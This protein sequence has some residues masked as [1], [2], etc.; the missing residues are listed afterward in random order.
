MMGMSAKA[1]QISHVEGGESERTEFCGYPVHQLELL[2]VDYKDF[3]ERPKLRLPGKG[4]ASRASLQRSATHFM[5]ST[6]FLH[7]GHE[8]SRG[9]G[10]SSAS[11]QLVKE[12]SS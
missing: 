8:Y 10:L 7:S 3:R 6:F 2:G 5:A 12:T 9:S 4:S 1:V 11:R